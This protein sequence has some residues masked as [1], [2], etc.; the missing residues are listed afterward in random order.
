MVCAGS[1]E[2]FSLSKENGPES[3]RL[4]S[5]S[6]MLFPRPYENDSELYELFSYLYQ[7]RF[8]A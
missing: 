1:Y 6:E 3:N 5:R 2:S 8:F 7:S 4:C